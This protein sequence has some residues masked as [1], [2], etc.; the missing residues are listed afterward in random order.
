MGGVN[1]RQIWVIWGPLSLIFF[2]SALP[3]PPT[4][5][6]FYLT[7]FATYKFFLTLQLHIK[8]MKQNIFGSFLVKSM[9]IDQKIRKIISDHTEVVFIFLTSRSR[10]KYIISS[11]LGYI[12]PF[13]PA[14]LVFFIISR[15]LNMRHL[16][17]KNKISA[18]VFNKNI[19]LAKYFRKK[20]RKNQKVRKPIFW[21]LS[22]HFLGFL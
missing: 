1:K 19:F 21:L 11:I 22:R 18:K 4:A 7:R 20:N 12:R 14:Y 5:P 8:G 16:S 13:L 2:P 6:K 9:F 17:V 10:D 15:T 3:H